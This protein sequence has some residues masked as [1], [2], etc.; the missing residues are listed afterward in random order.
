[1]QNDKSCWNQQTEDYIISEWDG[2][3]TKH[4]FD[5]R[6]DETIQPTPN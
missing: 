3:L 5:G 1:M 2:V 6:P 4:Y